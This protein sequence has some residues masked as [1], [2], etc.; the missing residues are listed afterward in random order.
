MSTSDA[1]Q[2]PKAEAVLLVDDDDLFVRATTRHLRALGYPYV[3]RAC[4]AEEALTLLER[5]RPSVVL[6]D[7]VMENRNAGHWVIAA[8]RKLN[9][10]VAV[11]SGL[12]GVADHVQGLR[13]LNKSDL[14]APALEALMSDL[15]AEHRYRRRDS[16]SHLRV[17]LNRASTDRRAG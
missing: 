7:M 9:I 3:F 13:V 15:V 17:S 11:I 12:P 6:T 16:T 1:S 2:M 10:A 14:D 4:S 5:V 8:A